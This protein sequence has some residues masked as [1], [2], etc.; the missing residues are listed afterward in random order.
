MTWSFDDSLPT[1]KDRVRVLIGDTDA[2]DQLLSDE[3]IAMYLPGGTLAKASDRLAAA[4]CA[5]AIAAKFIR[6]ANSLS[7]GGG[8]VNWGDRAK[9]YREL[10]A[11]LFASDAA[12]QSAGA[13]F[14]IAEFAGDAFSAR[15]RLNNELLRGAP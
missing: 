6:K 1:A 3:A 5:T 8:S 4:E 11:G 10:A 7:E 2:A 15:T 12:D 14:D 13:L 9:A